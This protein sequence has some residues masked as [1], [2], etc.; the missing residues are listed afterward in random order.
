MASLGAPVAP[1]AA[2]VADAAAALLRGVIV[3]AA[4]IAWV[5]DMFSA[6]SPLSARQ[7]QQQKH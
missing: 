6:L 1:A 5:L 3:V 4:S 7:E 2:A